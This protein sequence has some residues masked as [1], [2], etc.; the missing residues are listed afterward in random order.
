MLLV[1]YVG[2][3]TV[4]GNYCI[5][6]TLFHEKAARATA[7]YNMEL[8]YTFIFDI[9]VYNTNFSLAELSGVGLIVFGNLYMYFVNSE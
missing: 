3:A 1:L 5:N 2:V 7:Y 6:K 4:I 8:I 9:F